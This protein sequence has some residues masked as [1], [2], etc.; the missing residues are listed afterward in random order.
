MTDDEGLGDNAES[1][2]TG[3]AG[4]KMACAPIVWAKENFL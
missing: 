4:K 3:N 1:L 2:I